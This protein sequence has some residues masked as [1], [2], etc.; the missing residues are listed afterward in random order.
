MIVD[1]MPMCSCNA[2]AANAV[3]APRAEWLM[4]EHV[5]FA[6]LLARKMTGQAASDC[7]GWHCLAVHN[8]VVRFVG[9]DVDVDSCGLVRWI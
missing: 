3:R 4:R 8:V 7:F 2:L 1:S 5:L 6:F 9:V